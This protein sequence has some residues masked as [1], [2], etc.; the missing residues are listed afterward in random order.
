MSHARSNGIMGSL[1]SSGFVNLGRPGQNSTGFSISDAFEE[2]DTDEVIKVYGNASPMAMNGVASSKTGAQ[3]EE[4]V[5]IRMEPSDS[6]RYVSLTC[7]S[8]VLY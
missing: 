7:P 5:K 1:R 2:E 6:N 4:G 8:T 3:D